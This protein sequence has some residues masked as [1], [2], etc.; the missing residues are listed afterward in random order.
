MFGDWRVKLAAP[1]ILLG[2]LACSTPAPEK[3]EAVAMDQ[4]A[5]PVAATVVDSE[6]VRLLKK[7]MDYV[8]GLS[9][10]RVEVSNLHE[11]LLP[12]GHRVDYQSVAVGTVVRPNKIRGSRLGAGVEQDLIYDGTTLTVYNPPQQAYASVAAPPTIPGMFEMASDSLGLYIPITDLIWPDVFPLLMEGVTMAAVV[13]QELVGGVICTHLVFS[14]PG[15][16]FQIWIPVE[17]APLPLKYIVTD[18]STPALL[19]IVSTMSK[20]DTNPRVADDYF[21][22]TP[23][24]G[25]QQVPFIPLS[26]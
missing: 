5:A 16:D 13:D 25:A 9:R 22:F 26:N 21:T 17:G 12:S 11:D 8:G 20:W 23:P 18:T 19:S 15:A 14:R 24:A 1:G 7:S 2:V 6:A 3:G 10:F 4:A